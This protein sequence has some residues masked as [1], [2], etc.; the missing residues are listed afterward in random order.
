[1]NSFTP[2]SDLQHEIDRAVTQALEEDVGAGD[3]TANLVPA[4]KVSKATVLSRE[5]A[6]LCGVPW[7]EAVFRRLD[8]SVQITWHAR[9]SDVLEQNKVFCEISGDARAMLTAE[10][11]ALNFLQ[12][13]SATATRTREYVNAVKGLKAAIVDT[14][15]T[16]PGLRLAQKYAVR[17]GGGKNHRVGLYDGVLIKENHIMAAGGIGQALKA[18]RASVQ[19][20]VMVMIE[21]ESLVDLVDALNHGARLVLLDNFSLAQLREAVHINGGRAQLEA[22]GGVDLKTVRAI[23][24]TGVDRISIGTLTK[25]VDAIDLSMRF[26]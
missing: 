11:T 26:K 10:R 9:E 4:G 16:I 2:P 14:R 18:A 22:S 25:D 7:F 19:E 1:M 5:L 3:L 21:V 12:T 20:G 15:K 8:P 23:A 17:V 13:L 24:E 6:V